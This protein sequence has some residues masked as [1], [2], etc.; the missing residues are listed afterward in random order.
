M[1]MLEPENSVIICLCSLSARELGRR[2]RVGWV[3]QGYF[4]SPLPQ[5]L[6]VFFFLFFL[7]CFCFFLVLVD[8]ES[9]TLSWRCYSSVN[10][11]K[12]VRSRPQQ[13]MKRKREEE[14][15]FQ[16]PSSGRALALHAMPSC[17]SP[18]RTNRQSNKR[19]AQ[20]ITRSLL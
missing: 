17:V 13:Q 15:M 7:N 6:R 18:R 9:S 4:P 12:S 14:V 19:W 8:G 3:Q 5:P 20:T 11:L 2:G 16:A 10:H 1:I